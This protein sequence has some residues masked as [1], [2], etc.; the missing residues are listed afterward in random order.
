[1]ALAYSAYGAS[2]HFVIVLVSAFLLSG[3]AF[4]DEEVHYD[5]Q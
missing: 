3:E 1:M 5:K 4:F 2:Y